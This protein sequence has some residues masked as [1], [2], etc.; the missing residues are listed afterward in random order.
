MELELIKSKLLEHYGFTDCELKSLDGYIS[1]NYRVRHAGGTCLLK[2][3]QLNNENIADVRAENSIINNLSEN[4]SDFPATISTKE[5]EDIIVLKSEQ[6]FFRV[7][8]FLE[9][10]VLAL[11]EHPSSTIC[12]LGKLIGEMDSMLISIQNQNI[13]AR[14]MDWDLEHL[15]ELEPKLDLIQDARKRKI[16]DYFLVQW[17]TFITPQVLHLRKSI[18]HNDVNDWNVIVREDE[19]AGII[20]FGDMVYSRLVFEIAIAAAYLAIDKEDPVRALTDLFKSYHEV[21]PLLKEEV[22]LL[23]YLVAGRLCMSVLHSAKAQKDRPDNEYLLVSEEGAWNLLVRWLAISPVH[24]TRHWLSSLGFATTDY[25]DPVPLRRKS[26]PE[27]YSLSY[28]RP[29]HMVKAAFQYMYGA[30]G[31]TFLDAYN[32]IKHVGHCHPEIVRRGQEAMATLNTNT[33]Y[34]YNE[35]PDYASHLLSHFPPHLNKVFFVNS[36]SAASD[37][38]IR[39]ARTVTNRTQI[40]G[41]EQGYHGNTQLGIDVSHYK[42]AHK[43]GRGQKSNIT[44]LPLPDQFRGIYSGDSN[45]YL[46]DVRGILENS[47]EPAAFIAEPIIGCGGQMPF[48]SE[49]LQGIYQLI[50]D[51]GGICISDEVQVGFGRLGRWFW[52]YEMLDV[53]PDIVV[54]GK[55]MGNG[56]PIG[57]VV[58]TSEIARKFNNGMEFFSSFGGN[59][60]SCSVANAVLTVLKEERLRENAEKTGAYLVKRLEELSKEFAYIGDIRGKGLFLGVDLVKSPDSKQPHGELA[61]WLINAM[62]EHHI[63]ISLDGPG[64]NVLKIKSPLCFNKQNCDELVDRMQEC[65]T[66]WRKHTY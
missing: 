22:E 58:T 35:L 29:I 42:Y 59:P 19:V 46:K 49:I 64:H 41:I 2:V 36:G 52:G 65:L 56:H 44:V 10:N 63:L 8:S 5:G 47:P 4:R 12:S 62:R 15:L 27:V 16:V 30:D 1:V 39:I 40:V 7:L 25:K 54:L 17:K 66:Q 13:A 33:R 32:N 21:V 11:V 51:R 57:A 34:L 48:T 38:A 60:V 24:A 37:L 61:K 23:Y 55:P 43:G 20:D 6:L 14:K 26:I 28:E 53:D 45:G 3:Y 18:I 50:Q 31:S 9:G